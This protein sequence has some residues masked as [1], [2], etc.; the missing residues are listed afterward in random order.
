MVQAVGSSGALHV[1]SSGG[2]QQLQQIQVVPVSGL[3]VSQYY[4]IYSFNKDSNQ[5]THTKFLFKK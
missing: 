1:A 4:K 5:H 3:Q 2:G